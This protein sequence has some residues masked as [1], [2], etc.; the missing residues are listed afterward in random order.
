[1]PAKKPAYRASTIWNNSVKQRLTPNYGHEKLADPTCADLIDVFE[2]AWKGYVLSQVEVL[3]NNPNGDIA[4]MTLL[5]SYFES[6]EAL[7]RGESSDRQSRE[8]FVRGFLRVF[9]DVSDP[10]AARTAAE[11]IYRQV[12]CGVAHTAFPTRVV[13][14]QRSYRAAF[15]VTY[16]LV[17]NGRIGTDSPIA[18]VLV[19]AERMYHAVNWDLYRYLKTLRC[20]N[21][22]TLRTHFERLVRNEW[23]IGQGDNIVGMTKEEF[24]RPT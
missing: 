7:H 19:N 20:P 16:R 24:M 17:P 10:P 13:H 3:L 8:F 6:I 21:E 18:S 9:E 11:A 15:I 14:I 12:R 22:I 5:C 2:D 1:M 4:A 23:G